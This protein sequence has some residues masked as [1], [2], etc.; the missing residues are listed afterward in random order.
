MIPNIGDTVLYLTYNR[1]DEVIHFGSKAPDHRRV[2]RILDNTDGNK[3][4]EWESSKSQGVCIPSTWYEWYES[5]NENKR[6]GLTVL[7][8]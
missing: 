2:I 1:M 8:F 6:R 3:I 4:V 5:A 7:H